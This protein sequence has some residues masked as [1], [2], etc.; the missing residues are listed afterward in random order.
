MQW[1]V[2]VSNDHI[3]SQLTSSLYISQAST[4]T[5]NTVNTC[6]PFL[7]SSCPYHMHS[8]TVTVL[9]CPVS[10]RPHTLCMH[11]FAIKVRAPHTH[12][13]SVVT[14]TRSS[15]LAFLNTSCAGLHFA[16]DTFPSS[17]PP[18]IT[19]WSLSSCGS[20]CSG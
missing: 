13:L 18:F 12:H 16:F 20:S 9:S 7:C 1:S 3:M 17:H 10:Q 8:D 19:A 2:L 6:R 14:D 15:P 11:S 5:V 4:L